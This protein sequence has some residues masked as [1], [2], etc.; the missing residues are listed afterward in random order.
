MDIDSHFSD[1]NNGLIIYF[2]LFMQCLF[3][4][5]LSVDGIV[6][7]RL[8]FFSVNVTRFTAVFTGDKHWSESCLT[9]LEYSTGSQA[10]SLIRCV[11]APYDLIILL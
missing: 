2:D 1:S 3:Q 9:C 7:S 4:H 11:V 6:C 10:T 8:L 5:S